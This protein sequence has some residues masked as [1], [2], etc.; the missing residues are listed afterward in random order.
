M[1]GAGRQ[2]VA[3]L[4]QS[5]RGYLRGSLQQIAVLGLMW[6]RLKRGV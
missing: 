1:C 5:S 4:W 2:A 6:E 3:V